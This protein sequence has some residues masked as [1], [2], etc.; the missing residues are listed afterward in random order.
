MQGGKVKELRDTVENLIRNYQK[1]KASDVSAS[2]AWLK[3]MRNEQKVVEGNDDGSSRQ[4]TTGVALTLNVG[5]T[6]TVQHCCNSGFI[7]QGPESVFVG[8]RLR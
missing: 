8:F 4:I 6:V 2:Y 1:L 7:D 3:V 5:D